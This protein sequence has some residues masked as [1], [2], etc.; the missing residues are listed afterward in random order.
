MDARTYEAE[1]PTLADVASLAG[2]SRAT[3]SRVVNDLPT[4]SA[5]TRRRVQ[6]A[7]AALGYVPDAAAVALARRRGG[8]R[9]NIPR[10]PAA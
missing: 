6:R 7:V 10:L 3:A 1:T 5:D 2:V 9:P 8:R 4:V